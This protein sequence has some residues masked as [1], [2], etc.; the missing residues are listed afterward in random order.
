MAA[1][2]LLIR[3]RATLKFLFV[4]ALGLVMLIPLVMIRS[5]VTERQRLQAAAART[6]AGRWGGA[7]TVGGLVALREAEV[8]SAGAR[9]VRKET[10]WRAQAASTLSID[11]ELTTEERYLGIY[12]VPVYTSS[13]TIRG[14]LA[15]DRLDVEAPPGEL[16][17]WLP[18]NDVRGVREVSS[19]ELGA[20]EVP[21]R[22][23][24]A[25]ASQL[26][27]L[28]FTL[29]AADRRA[30]GKIQS[31]DYRLTLTLA[32][33]G[34]LQFLPLADTTRVS[35]TSDWPHPEFIGQYLPAS[36]QVSTDGARAEWR[37]LGLNRPFGDEWAVGELP[38][39]EMA[40]AA[41]GMRLETP[42]DVYQRSERSVK[43]GG[44]FIALTFL[45]LFL[46]EVTGDKSLHPVPYALTGAAL[47]VF[48]LVLMALSEY[49]PFAAAF[50]L[51]AALLVGMVGPYTGA[52][53][54]AR[55]GLAAASMLAVTYALLYV[56]VSAQQVSL[57]VGSLS[58]L[59][60]IAGLMYLT[61]KVDWYGY[62]G[63]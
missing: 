31:V 36:R 29:S 42:V 47:A 32:G 57:L 37:L 24:T 63:S 17:L 27:G 28:Q 62:G 49:L 58:L 8:R 35:L 34:S 26:S 10:Q 45:T 23:L 15:P 46:F 40:R 21:A 11:A 13:I 16:T 1:T 25:L 55:R 4:G 59:A 20:L 54:G 52:L 9:V 14:R 22:P 38:G 7:Q 33:S 3:H 12:T 44:L 53:L 41:F 61:R 18:L 56:L 51:A 19:L 6:V 43:Y 30:L 50:A 39:E 48:Y 60:A 5:V 2:E